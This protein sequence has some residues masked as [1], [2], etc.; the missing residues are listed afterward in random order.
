MRCGTRILPARVCVRRQASSLQISGIPRRPFGLTHSPQWD[1]RTKTRMRSTRGTLASTFP[2]LTIALQLAWSG[3]PRLLAVSLNHRMGHGA[4]TR[5]AQ[6]RGDLM[7]STWNVTR[8]TWSKVS[9]IFARAAQPRR[10]S[11]LTTDLPLNSNQSR[12]RSRY[13]SRSLS[14]SRN[15]SLPQSQSPRCSIRPLDRAKR[16]PSSLTPHW[17]RLRCLLD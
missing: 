3:A 7:R 4:A 2:S 1:R 17:R 15:R 8:A 12:N 14:L 10:W 13:Q 16:S 9:A 6:L 11:G 5:L